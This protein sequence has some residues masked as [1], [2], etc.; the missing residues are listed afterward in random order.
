MAGFDPS[1]LATLGSAASGAADFGM[2]NFTSFLNYMNGLR[3]AQHKRL[4]G[5]A[6]NQRF[7]ARTGGDPDWRN[8]NTQVAPQ[9]DMQAMWADL[10]PFGIG[11]NLGK[12]M[13]PAPPGATPSGRKP[14]QARQTYG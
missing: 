6:I 10:L 3:A 8:V 12:M 1:M 7:L 13:Y 5:N 14:G 11:E 9:E 4:S 2:G